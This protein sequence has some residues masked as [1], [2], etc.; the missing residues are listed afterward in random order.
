MKTKFMENV[1]K[2]QQ[3]AVIGKFVVIFIY[4]SA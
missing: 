4:L 2:E 1:Q 3:S